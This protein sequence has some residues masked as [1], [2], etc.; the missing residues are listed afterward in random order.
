MIIKFVNKNTSH[1]MKGYSVKEAFDQNNM[2]YKKIVVNDDKYIPSKENIGDRVF[3]AGDSLNKKY[4]LIDIKDINEEGFLG[5]AYIIKS[6]DTMRSINCY[7]DEVILHPDNFKRKR[8]RR[9]KVKK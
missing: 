8:K 4:F 6:P 9:K 3:W 7:M 1:N 2:K 5:G